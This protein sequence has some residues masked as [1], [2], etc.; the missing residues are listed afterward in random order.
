MRDAN[1]TSRCFG[2]VNFQNPDAVA[3]AVENLNGTSLTDDKVLYVGR[4]QRKSERDAELRAK[5]EQESSRFEKLQGANRYLKNL[6]D[7]INDEKLKDLFF[8][9]GN[10]TSC[11]VMLDAQGANKG[12]GFVAFSNPEEATRALNAMNGKMIGQKS[13]YVA[14]AQRKEE[15]R[16]HLQVLF[17][18][19]TIS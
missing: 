7:S 6:D 2:F 8:E 15:R 18:H 19:C 13:L 12:S 9:F 10:I 17:L 14:V 11:K 16:A 1:G 3:A 4:A 5:F